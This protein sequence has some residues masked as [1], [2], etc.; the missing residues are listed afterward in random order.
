MTECHGNNQVLSVCISVLAQSVSLP[1][2]EDPGTPLIGNH[3]GDSFS[4]G[5]RGPGMTHSS[6]FEMEADSSSG[7][8]L[9]PVYT[10]H[11]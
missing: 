2:Y 4:G 5:R 9:T 10:G 8:S 6:F 1:Q 7:D 3:K 11:H